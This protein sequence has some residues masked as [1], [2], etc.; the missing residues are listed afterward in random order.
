VS[1]CFSCWSSLFVLQSLYGAAIVLESVRSMILIYSCQG[2]CIYFILKC[3]RTCISCI[4]NVFSH[5]SS[6][7]PLVESEGTKKNYYKYVFNQT[8][9]VDVLSVH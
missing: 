6:S 5:H 8:F 1:L 3:N 7:K 4:S 2:L 9:F